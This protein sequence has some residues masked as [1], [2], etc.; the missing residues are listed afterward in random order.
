MHAVG[1]VLAL[2]RPYRG[3]L[4]LSQV[5]LLLSAGCTLGTAALNARLVNDGLLAGDTTVIV[6][7]GLWM[8]TLGVAAG[9][10]LTGV[11]VI[12]V[13]F[14]Q[15][16]AYAL[17]T[18]AY[19]SI[20]RFSFGNFDAMRTGNLL[21]R[22]NSDVTNV[23]N[24]VLFGVMLLLYAPFMLVVSVGLALVDTP[25]MVWILLLV[26]AAV[27]AAATVLVPPMERAYAERQRR[28]DE[29]NSALQENLAGV[30]VVKAFGREKLEAA[31]FDERT[32]ALRRPAASAAFRV[33]LLSPVLTT[34]T[35]LGI[36][37]TLLVGGD[38]VVANDGT[39]IGQVTAF[40]Q[41]LSLVVVPLALAAVI[42][43]YL[44][45]GATSARRVFE[46]VDTGPTLPEGGQTRV[47]DQD[48]ARVVFTGV[49][50]S[51][52]ESGEAGH[53]VLH[54]IDLVIEPGQSVGILG[55][56]GSGK[57]SLVNLV[58][59]FYDVRAGSVTID[60]VDVRDIPLDQLR[61][62]VST[63]L[64]EAVLFQGDVRENVRFASP[65]AT[66]DRIHE[67]ARACDAFDFVE[68]LPQRWDSPVAR[69]G[70]NFSGGQRQ[71]LSMA[72]AL[73]PRP[74]VL[75]LD[76]STSALDVATET[77]VQAAI[78]QDALGT[79]VIYVA[80]RISAVID[81]DRIVLLD[82]GRIA[83]QGT[84][85]ELLGRSAL[86]REIYESQLGPIAGAGR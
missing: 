10:L 72:R 70:Y 16:T 59:R 68:A 53:D 85:T 5:L 69:R 83:D 25:G 67:A 54:G 26:A 66:D 6:D 3:R 73:V 17:R 28:L 80:Q 19:A 60:D 23:A 18:Q 27:L 14:S 32:E 57:T 62:V 82:E 30:R 74:R 13:F 39:S 4:I 24:A 78:P 86:Y 76:D 43:P 33:A 65:E 44:L 81:L 29:V 41:Y 34:V 20:Q 58:P 55:P 37:L 1:R 64:Q 56:T 31:R 49:R 63:A 51:Y 2:Y 52:D 46:L 36:V 8:A 84:H 77:R 21:V 45:R 11:A 12:A 38:K 15:G 7:T 48:G 9:L 22:L 50:F 71:R 35:Q 79:T 40:I 42:A 61:A 47:A 75:I